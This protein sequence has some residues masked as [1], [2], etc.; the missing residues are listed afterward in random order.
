M[1]PEL[2]HLQWYLT[3]LALKGDDMVNFFLDVHRYGK[4]PKWL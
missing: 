4:I 1:D 3:A 2:N